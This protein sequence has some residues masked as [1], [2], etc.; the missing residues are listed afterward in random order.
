MSWRSA[1]TTDTAEGSASWTGPAKRSRKVSARKRHALV[2]WLRR[3]AAH[4]TDRGPRRR[5][6]VVLLP[7]RVAAVRG[8]LLEVAD[9]LETT[10]APDPACVAD[11]YRLLSDGC[12]SPLYN[13]DVHVSELT[14]TL[15]Y[16]RSALKD[17]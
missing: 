9:L 11:L 8:D 7:D 14:A 3:A 17:G 16:A 6:F 10:A 15:Y 1:A 12:E 2:R 13:P 5:R 4:T